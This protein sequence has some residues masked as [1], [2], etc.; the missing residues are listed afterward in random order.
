MD[1]PTLNYTEQPPGSRITCEQ[2]DDGLAL[3][4]LPHDMRR[5]LKVLA[6]LAGL[7]AAVKAVVLLL[8]AHRTVS[9]LAAV[10][11]QLEIPW[12]RIALQIAPL[13]AL[14][15]TS[16]LCVLLL[17]WWRTSVEVN[18]EKLGVD[19]RGLFWRR[20]GWWPRGRVGG[21]DLTWFGVIVRSKDRRVLRRISLPRR[22]RHW[23]ANRLRAA[24][25]VD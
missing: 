19:S 18:P 15:S 1:A 8:V 10:G 4:I 6:V 17:T 23:F 16:W 9:Q 24:L 2:R 21:V 25:G 20:R 12:G 14:A 13:T 5:E 7:Y 22:D 11:V 3:V